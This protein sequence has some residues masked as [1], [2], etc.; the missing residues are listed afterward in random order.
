MLILE[1]SQGCYGRT[2][3]RKDRRKDGR[4]V[5]LLYPQ[6]QFHL[7]RVF[8][9]YTVILIAKWMKVFSEIRINVHLPYHSNKHCTEIQIIV[10]VTFF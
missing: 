6:V 4:T 9:K 1:C 7:C 2:D 8:T 5:A 3:G 10:M